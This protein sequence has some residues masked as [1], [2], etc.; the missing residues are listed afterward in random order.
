MEKQE[1]YQNRKCVGWKFTKFMDTLFPHAF[2][3]N[4]NNFIREIR[5]I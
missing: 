1:T 2:T 3:V 4:R 5:K